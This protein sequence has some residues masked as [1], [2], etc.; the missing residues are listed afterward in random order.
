MAVSCFS[1][2]VGALFDP[3]IKMIMM[4]NMLIKNKQEFYLFKM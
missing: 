3:A 4:K 1:F 2:G